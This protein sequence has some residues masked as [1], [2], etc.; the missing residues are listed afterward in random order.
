[1]E[2]ETD[3]AEELRQIEDDTKKSSS[4][5]TTA[6][7][8][9]KSTTTTAAAIKGEE[10]VKPP[11]GKKMRPS[12]QT[13]YDTLLDQL[14]DRLKI[15]RHPDSLVTIKAV[16][17]LIENILSSS[18]PSPSLDPKQQLLSADS[19]SGDNGSRNQPL[20]AADRTTDLTHQQ[21]AIVSGGNNNAGARIQRTKFRLDDV[22]LPSSLV[23]SW[24]GLGMTPQQQ[25]GAGGGNT[26]KEGEEES[27][28]RSEGKDELKGALERASK[29]L[30]LLYLND[31]KQLQLQVNEI[32]SSVQ[33]IT[34]NPKTDSKLLSSAAR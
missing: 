30:K 1:M 24:T 11:V 32:I 14:A 18:S 31:Q 6:T 16:R 13:E 10:K 19:R 27:I 26:T 8:T 22:S 29:S 21:S 20:V 4:T 7:A 3:L 15:V 2:C 17:L 34:A 12:D 5:T 25:I 23:S 33:S 28:S 9:A